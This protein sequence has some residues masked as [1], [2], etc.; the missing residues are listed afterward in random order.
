[1]A[2]QLESI[3]QPLIH[4]GFFQAMQKQQEDTRA[5]TLALTE[6][7]QKLSIQ[8]QPIH[9]LMEKL[10]INIQPVIKEFQTV[11]FPIIGEAI[12]QLLKKQNDFYKAVD[13]QRF[14]TTVLSQFQYTYNDLLSL[15]ESDKFKEIPFPTQNI[16]VI[17]ALNKKD[18]LTKKDLIKYAIS[19]AAIYEFISAV[20]SMFAFFFPDDSKMIE[21]QENLFNMNIENQKQFRDINNII[22]QR[23]SS[24]HQIIYYEVTKKV[25]IREYPSSENNSTILDTAL[26]KQKLLLLDTTSYWIQIEYF[27]E[28]K[29]ETII[30]WVSKRYT[31]L[32]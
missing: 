11:Q 14:D 27:N 15:Q 1:M 10:A 4:S 6:L 12:T 17:E 29:N 23:Q 26:P 5:L 3:Q 31:K 30:G 18:T 32:L 25:N 19:V 16:H 13:F 9:D 28:K 20:I 7:M 21:I 2:K 22:D 8:L 24:F